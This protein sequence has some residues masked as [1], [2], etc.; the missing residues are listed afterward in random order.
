ML[1]YVSKRNFTVCAFFDMQASIVKCLMAA[2]S[3]IPTATF[4]LQITFN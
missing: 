4:V 2:D 3:H 1:V